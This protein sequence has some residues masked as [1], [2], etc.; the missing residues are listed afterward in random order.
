MDESRDIEQALQH[1][2]QCHGAGDLRQAEQ[3]YRRIL[4]ANPEHPDA[5]HYLGVVGLQTGRFEDAVELISKAVEHRPEYVDALV[6]LGNAMQALD[7]YDDAIARYRQATEIQPGTAT[8][9]ANLANALLQS[10]QHSKAIDNYTAALAIEPGLVDAR[11]NLADALLAQGRPGEALRQIKQAASSGPR[12]L[13]VQVS[14]GNI[15]GEL[16]RSDEAIACFETVLKARPDLAPVYCNLGNVLRQA[17]RQTEAIEYYNKALSLD[18]DY[19]EGHYDLGLAFQDLGDKDKALAAFRQ[20]IALDRHCTKAWRAIASQSRNSLTDDDFLTMQQALESSEYSPEQ[21]MYL[22]F[23][24]GK[25]Y[26]DRSDHKAAIEHY[27]RGNRLR[28]ATVDYSI[29]RDKQEFDNLKSSFDSGFFERWSGTGIA[30]ATPIFIVGMP[31][32]GTTLV[33]QILASHPSI[34]GG[35]ELQSLPRAIAERFTM[36]DG[37]DYTA[38]LEVADEADFEFIANRYITAIRE[39]DG[40]ALHITDKLPMNFLNVGLMRILFPNA[41]VIHCVRDARDT[42]YSIYKHFFSAR[43]HH[44]AY[45]LEEL[46]RYYNLYADLMAQWQ[47]MLP[48]V[49]YELRYESMVA[50]QEATTRALLDACGLPW[51]PA[52][53]EFH[54]TA[55][56]V[57]TISASQ[58]R[59][60]MYTGSVGAWRN[61]EESLA[62]LLRVLGN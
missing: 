51:D 12:A 39:M 15:L 16:G 48:D 34:F 49:L 19:V 4:G 17:G 32:S 25:G 5:L 7:R 41:R 38:A 45:D 42:C 26:E 13:E 50:E 3:I 11:R 10:G 27:H 2:L 58:V 22:E 18:S 40:E 33:E 54:K 62:P 47:Q 61:Y 53:L 60:P 43:G 30:D 55:R 52:C 14:M 8:I 37:V 57:T 59:Q 6:N 56:P 31:R 44:Y 36:H 46:G 29:E 35:G 9:I 20:A 28:R 23:A 21:V 1:A 24:L